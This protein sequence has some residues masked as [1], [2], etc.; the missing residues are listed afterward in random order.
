MSKEPNEII[1]N[2]ITLGDSGVGKTSLLRRYL[3]IY[4]MIILCPQLD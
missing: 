2:I 1:F 3:L 4:M